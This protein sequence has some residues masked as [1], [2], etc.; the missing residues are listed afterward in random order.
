MLR[1]GITP[2]MIHPGFFN[3]GVRRGLH[4]KNRNARSNRDPLLIYF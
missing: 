3:L 2:N 4:F 1:T